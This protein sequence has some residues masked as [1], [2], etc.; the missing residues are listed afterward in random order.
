[1][2]REPLGKFERISAPHA[3]SS[4]GWIIK[5]LITIGF[6][7]LRISEFGVPYRGHFEEKVI[8]ASSTGDGAPDD[9]ST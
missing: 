6:R 3:R 7:A 4:I 5:I 1:M 9:S 8:L 2:S